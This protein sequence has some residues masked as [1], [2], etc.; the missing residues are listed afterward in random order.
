PSLF[1]APPPPLSE[2]IGLGCLPHAFLELSCR[3]L[4]F[5]GELLTLIGR[6]PI[7]AARHHQRARALRIGEA[8]MQRREATHGEPDDMRLVEL[9]RVEDGT[10]V[11]ARAILRITL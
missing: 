3:C 10:N 11:I 1:F 9:Q 4:R 8:E 7:A 6:G 2:R 5:L